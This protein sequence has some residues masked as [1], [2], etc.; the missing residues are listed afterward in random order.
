[1]LFSSARRSISSRKLEGTDEL[2]VR[3]RADGPVCNKMSSTSLLQTA[4]HTAVTVSYLRNDLLCT[5]EQRK[6]LLSYL[7]G[8][9]S[10]N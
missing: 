10:I 9:I 1:M 7:L 4:L 6:T 8:K 2:A 3:L 5:V